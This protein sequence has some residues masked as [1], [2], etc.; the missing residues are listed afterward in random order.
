[1][2]EHR[3]GGGGGKEE[4]RRRRRRK[5]DGMKA[6]RSDGDHDHGDDDEKV[7]RVKMTRLSFGNKTTKNVE[8]WM[9]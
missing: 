7:V 6:T 9:K 5:G 8:Q 1:M 2:L 3:D 4:R